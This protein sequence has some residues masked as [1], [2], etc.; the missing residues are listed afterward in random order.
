MD[1]GALGVDPGA[2]GMDLETQ[3]PTLDL[4]RVELGAL[5]VNLGNPASL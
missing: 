4:L 5:G 3:R 1:L 2:P